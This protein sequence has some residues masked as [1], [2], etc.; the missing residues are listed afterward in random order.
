LQRALGA[1]VG[2]Q[3]RHSPLLGGV[4]EV[5]GVADPLVTITASNRHR[6]GTQRRQCLRDVRPNSRPFV[7]QQDVGAAEVVRLFTG[8]LGFVPRR[9]V[10]PVGDVPRP[11][12]IGTTRLVRPT[13]PIAFAFKRIRRQAHAPAGLCLMKALPVDVE[14]QF[15]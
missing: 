3:I 8:K 9:H 14:A 4:E 10:E 12:C 1:H 13:D 11:G 2:D 7:Q 6:H 15:P 5:F